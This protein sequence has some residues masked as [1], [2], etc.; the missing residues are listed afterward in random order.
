ML[1]CRPLYIC[2]TPATIYC[3]FALCLL[4]LLT[5]AGVIGFVVIKTLDNQK[6]PKPDNWCVKVKY[7]ALFSN[8]S[9]KSCRKCLHTGAIKGA[10][11]LALFFFL[12]GF[13]FS[14]TRISDPILSLQL[15]LIGEPSVILL[16]KHHCPGLPSGS[17]HSMCIWG[18]SVRVSARENHRVPFCT[19][20][21]ATCWSH[22]VISSPFTTKHLKK[23]FPSKMPEKRLRVTFIYKII[24]LPPYLTTDSALWE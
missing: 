15:W 13:I 11:C 10:R 19:V 16:L 23:V 4:I 14:P 9:P 3:R 17:L 1:Q 5:F 18:C 12:R 24:H 20:C 7:Y 22:T 6:R 8:S 2:I 21:A